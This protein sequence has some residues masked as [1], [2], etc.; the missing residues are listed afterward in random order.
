VD[1]RRR[2]DHVGP[3]FLARVREVVDTGRLDDTF[4]DA[5][6]DPPEVFT[7]GGMV[8]H[9]VTFAAYNRTLASSSSAN[10]ASMT[11]GGEPPCAGWRNQPD[12]A[13]RAV[14]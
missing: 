7:Y 4:I 12:I 5:F 1:V 2:L 3:A 11:S 8:A 13:N 14:T 6:C 9:V 10:S